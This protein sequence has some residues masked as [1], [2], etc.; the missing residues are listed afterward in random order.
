M[1]KEKEEEKETTYLRLNSRNNAGAV[2]WPLCITVSAGV[3]IQFVQLPSRGNK[4][5]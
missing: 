2:C 3:S 1:Q 5:K 4:H